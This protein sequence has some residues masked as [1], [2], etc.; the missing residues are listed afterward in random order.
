MTAKLRVA[1][2]FGG[3]SGEH[4]VSIVSAQAVLAALDRERYAVETVGIT[5]DGQWIS[6]AGALAELIARADQAKLPT[7]AGAAESGPITLLGRIGSDDWRMPAADIYFPV[8]HGPHGEDGTLQGM[9]ELIGKPYVGCGVAAA[10]LGMDKALMKA[11]FAA[12][13][14][15]IL[16]WLMVQRI[17]WESD[18]SAVLNRVEHELHYPVFVKPA[19]MGSSVGVSKARHR[20]ELADAV[21]L[22]AGYDRRIVI[23]QGINA[24]EIEVSVL[25]N[26]RPAASVPGEIIPSGEWYDYNAKYID[27]GSQTVIPAALSPAVTADVQQL[28]MRAF[29]AVDGAG[30]SRVDFLLDRDN[31]KLWLN[32][33]NTMPGFTPISMYPKL[34]AAAGMKYSE[35]IDRLIDLARERHG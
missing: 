35:L 29:L 10:A 2:L 31:G 33:I 12:A 14:L 22:A 7:S 25:G 18:P 13:G 24:R 28:A 32:E 21:K 20:G 3:E 9:L 11:A 23:E 15:P 19:N 16:P 30:L 6:G 8:I 27:G 17:D 4:E 34:W 26:S 5:R 1:V